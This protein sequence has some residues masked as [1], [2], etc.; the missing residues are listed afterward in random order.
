MDGQAELAAQDFPDLGRLDGPFAGLIDA[1]SQIDIAVF[2]MAV[3]GFDDVLLDV[4]G[5]HAVPALVGHLFIEDA[6]CVIEFRQDLVE[7]VLAEVFRQ[8]AAQGIDGVIGNGHQLRRL[9]IDVFAIEDGKALGRHGVHTRH[10]VGDGQLFGQ[11]HVEV[12]HIGRDADAQGRGEAELHVRIEAFGV[13][14]RQFGP[15]DDVA[16]GPG[17]IQVRQELQGP[18]FLN[19]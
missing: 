1:D 15:D 6:G 12:F 17:K 18:V 19:S 11:F 10:D 13:T 2:H 3:D 7:S 4:D 9:G 14:D 5:A 16:H 8:R